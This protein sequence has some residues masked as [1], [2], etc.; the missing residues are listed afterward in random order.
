MNEDK[1]DS[2]VVQLDQ[3]GTETLVA[4]LSS[5]TKTEAADK[6]Q[7]HRNTVNERIERYGLDKI[8]MQIPQ[9]ALQTLQMGSDHAAET[10]V[11]ALESRPERLEAAKQILDRVGLSA[12][13]EQTNIQVNNIVPILGGR[14]KDELSSNNSDEQ[15]TET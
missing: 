6:L 11:R 12:P 15:T 9:R 1:K 5:K 4:L 10:L 7:V 14:T 2:K 13:K 3:T 8:I